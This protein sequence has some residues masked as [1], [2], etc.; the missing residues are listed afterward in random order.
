MAFFAFRFF[1]LVIK[2]V[3]F[4]LDLRLMFISIVLPFILNRM[5]GPAGYLPAIPYSLEPLLML[6]LMAVNAVPPGFKKSESGRK[7]CLLYIKFGITYFRT[8]MALLADNSFMFAL[9]SESILIFRF[10]TEG[11][12]LPWSA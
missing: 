12:F 1:G 10:M 5:T 11:V 4:E 9:E 6:L 8:F 2:L 3:F 7:L